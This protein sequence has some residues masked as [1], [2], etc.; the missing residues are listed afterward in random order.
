MVKCIILEIQRR[1]EEISREKIDTIYFGGGTPSILESNEIELLLSTIYSNFEVD[2]NAEITIEANP[3]DMKPDYIK[4]VRDLGINRLSLGIQSFL[5]RDL[6]LMR[7]SHKATDSLSAIENC[8]KYGF[9]NINIDLIYGIPGQDNK[10]WLNNLDIALSYNIQHLSAYHLTFESGTVFDHW[11][12]KGKISAV[13]EDTSIRQ[14][15]ILIDKLLSFGFEHY[16]ISNFALPGFISRHN[17][18]YWKQLNYIGLGPSA[19]SYDGKIRRWNISNNSR[20][21]QLLKS[22][23]NKYFEYEILSKKDLFNEYILTSLRT[24]WGV[25]I[26]EIKTRFGDEYMNYTV[27]SADKFISG[28][29]LVRTDTIIKLSRKGIFL[30]DYIISEIMKD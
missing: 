11:R 22:E 1:K 27:N 4:R 9:D 7:R 16:E 26:H 20:Y 12:K 15:E 5:D 30:A 19:H 24:K 21:I 28:G 10:E 17:T 2:L 3:D 8:K 18:S 29:E 13:N 6:E 23:R 25:D 14:L